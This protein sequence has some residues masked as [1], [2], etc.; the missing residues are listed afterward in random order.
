M[1]SSRLD[2]A[3][4]AC[5]LVWPC[6]CLALR[7]PVCCHGIP[8][9]SNYSYFHKQLRSDVSLLLRDVLD[10][11]RPAPHLLLRAVCSSC[12]SKFKDKCSFRLTFCVGWWCDQGRQSQVEVSVCAWGWS[13]IKIHWERQVQQGPRGPW[14]LCTH[15]PKGLA[16]YPQL[17]TMS[18]R[19]ETLASTLASLQISQGCEPRPSAHLFAHQKACARRLQVAWT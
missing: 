9:D 5:S 13:V 17:N 15:L 8:A 6:D 3:Y 19:W 1:F 18:W 10:F 16:P 7:S 12:L 11:A 4:L 14:R 2:S